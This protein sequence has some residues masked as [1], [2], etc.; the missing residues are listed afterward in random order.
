M[1][2]SLLSRAGLKSS[3]TGS[4]PQEST[5]SNKYNTKRYD[6]LDDSP[7]QVKMPDDPV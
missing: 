7:G 4:E 1:T 3:A 2:E 6:V 5:R